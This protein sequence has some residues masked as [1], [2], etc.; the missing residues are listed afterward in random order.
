MKKECIPRIPNLAKKLLA[1]FLGTLFLLTI[2]VG[3]GIMGE[4]LSHGDAAMALLANSAATG[5]GLTVLIWVFGSISRAHFNPLVTLMD[6]SHGHLNKKEI[7]LYILVQMIGALAGV[8]IAHLMFELPAFAM[9]SHDRSGLSQM[10]SEFVATFGLIMVIRGVGHHHKE[11][12][13][14][15]VG[16]YIASAYWFTS[17]TSFANPAVTLARSLTPTFSGIQISNVFGFIVAQILGAM[18]AEVTF[19]WFFD[20]QEEK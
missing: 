3:S 7:P 5:L 15:A 1:E 12:V 20:N 9:S 14:F 10:V 18:A 16:A 2:V 4:K 19:R 13:A 17:S 8:L 11:H 6:Y